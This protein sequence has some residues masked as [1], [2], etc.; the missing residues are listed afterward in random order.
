[1]NNKVNKFILFA[2]HVDLSKREKICSV[3]RRD[4][5]KLIMFMHCGYHKQN[6]YFHHP[7]NKKVPCAPFGVTPFP[8]TPVP[9]ILNLIPISTVLLSHFPYTCNH[10]GCST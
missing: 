2:T 7:E 5:F 3:Y 6:T 8:T 10:T 4:V 9:G 1:M